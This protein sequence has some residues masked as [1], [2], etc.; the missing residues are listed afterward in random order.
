MICAECGTENDASS[1]FCMGCGRS[2][3]PATPEVAGEQPFE[4]GPD[5]IA[6]AAASPGAPGATTEPDAPPAAPSFGEAPGAPPAPA[7]ATADAT[8]PPPSDL[9]PPPAPA[10]PDTPA[11]PAPPVPPAWNAPP[12]APAPSWDAPA[13]APAPPAAATPPAPPS[14][15]SWGPPAAAA[16]PA[17]PAWGQAPAASS[18]APASW[19]QPPAPTPGGWGAPAPAPTPVAPPAPTGPPDPNGLGAAASRLGNPARKSAK[20]TL[21]VAGALLEEGEAVEAVV[22]GKLQ[23]FAAVL[24]LTDRSLLLVDDRTW[25]PFVERFTLAP[26]FQIQGW[27]DDRTASLTIVTEKGQLV[28]D[29]IT[30]RP[31]AVEMAQRIRVRTG[32]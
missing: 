24:A 21:V 25:K 6:P 10:V 30:D 8:P 28:I 26:G 7:P 22:V 19:G 2:L 3:S 20:V 13:P 29:G 17:P 18:P 31:L 32:S 1:K 11:P 14:P 15:P 5:A 27:Q 12:A 23:G 4:P 16:P 9:P